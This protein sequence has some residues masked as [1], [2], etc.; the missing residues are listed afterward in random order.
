MSVP[1]NQEMLD[2]VKTAI[3]N[4]LN[5]GAIQSYSI[6][7]RNIQ[8]AT[9]DELQKMRRDLEAAIAGESGGARNFVSFSNPD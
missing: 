2:A 8:Y 5:G 7:G 9:L 3:Y 4:R 1:T 6:N